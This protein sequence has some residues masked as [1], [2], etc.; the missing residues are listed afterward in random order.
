M[1]LK[2]KTNILKRVTPLLTGTGVFP[3]TVKDIHIYIKINLHIYNTILSRI[4]ITHCGLLYNHIPCS[5]YF[6]V[7]QDKH[8]P[9]K[10]ANVSISLLHLNHAQNIH[11]F[12][13]CCIVTHSLYPN[14]KHQISVKIRKLSTHR[15]ILSRLHKSCFRSAD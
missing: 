12:D 5:R 8:L 3:A 14:L 13:V 1:Y 2:V 15:C 10:F 4:F 9:H 6:D 7:L 11:L